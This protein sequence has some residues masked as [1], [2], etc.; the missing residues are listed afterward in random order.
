MLND[1]AKF[2]VYL[3]CFIK[4]PNISTN[5]CINIIQ[6]MLQT[7]TLRLAMASPGTYIWGAKYALSYY[8]KALG[9][10]E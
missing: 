6:Y 4:S 1:K 8:I 9:K 10:E 7:N 5:I 2:P 3:A